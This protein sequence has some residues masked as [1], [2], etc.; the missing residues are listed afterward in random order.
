LDPQTKGQKSTDIN[1]EEIFFRR[2]TG[3]ALFDNKMNE[4]IVEE[5]KVEAVDGKIRQYKLNWL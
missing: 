5:M 4:E 3:Y 2:T 1:R